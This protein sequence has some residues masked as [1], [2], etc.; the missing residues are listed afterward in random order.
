MK[1]ILIMSLMVLFGCTTQYVQ[2]DKNDEAYCQGIK[3]QA[4]REHNKNAD[5]MYALCMQS[6]GYTQ[7]N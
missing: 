4:I 5:E 7:S 1:A 6:K 2:L 3:S